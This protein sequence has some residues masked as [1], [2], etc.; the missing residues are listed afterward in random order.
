MVEV[1]NYRAD[2]IL[3]STATGSTGHSFSAGGPILSPSVNAL[4]ITPICP[5]GMSVRPLVISNNEEVRLT[6]DAPTEEEWPYLTV[7]GHENR[8][9]TIGR[10]VYISNKGIS[11][12]VV[13]TR[14]YNF[15]KNLGDKLKWKN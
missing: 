10:E 11:V 9:L 13:R 3:I 8:R 4:V 12:P 5:M 6:V 2:G 15:H 14:D 1:S 7:D